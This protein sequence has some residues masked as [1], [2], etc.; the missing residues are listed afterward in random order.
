[1]NFRKN[2]L[3]FIHIVVRYKMNIQDEL[4]KFMIQY[5]AFIAGSNALQGYL[6]ADFKPGDLDLWVP[7][8][9]KD[10]YVQRINDDCEFEQNPYITEISNAFEELFVHSLKKYHDLRYT[11]RKECPRDRPTYVDL[12]DNFKTYIH[13]IHTYYPVNKSDPTIQVIYIYVDRDTLFKTF[14]FSF[15]ATAWDGKEYYT[16]EPLLTSRKVG[17]I[18]P[19]EQQLT[20]STDPERVREHKVKRLEKYKARGFTIYDSKEEA[21]EKSGLKYKNELMQTMYQWLGYK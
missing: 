20:V 18:Q 4:N 5:D 10:T 8:H 1:M 2:D 17:Y 14:D 13:R 12:H 9:K 21:M 3:G 6:K 11:I 7:I 19:L 15:C 16:L